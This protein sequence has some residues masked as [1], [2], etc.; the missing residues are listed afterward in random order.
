MVDEYAALIGPLRSYL[1]GLVCS[2]PIHSP[3]TKLF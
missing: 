2:R 1:V 3:Q